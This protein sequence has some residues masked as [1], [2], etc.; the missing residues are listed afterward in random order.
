MTGPPVRRLTPQQQ[1]AAKLVAES[2]TNK[3]IC[4]TMGLSPR[5]VETLLSEIADRWDLDRSRNLRAQIVTVYVRVF[6]F[7]NVGA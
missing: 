4:A 2:A 5:R 1:R 7:P 3:Q 6:G